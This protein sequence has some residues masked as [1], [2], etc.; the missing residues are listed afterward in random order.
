[1]IKQAHRK[2]RSEKEPYQTEWI[3]CWYFNY[4]YPPNYNWKSSDNPCHDSYYNS[5]RF[6]SR[7]IFAFQLGIIAKEGQD[8]KITFAVTNL[9]TT[10]P[11]QNTELRLF[12]YQN[13]H[14]QTLTTDNQGFASATFEKKPFFL[15]AQK[16]NQF[17]YPPS[18][19]G[20][21]LSTSTY[22]GGQVVN[23]RTER[24]YLWRTWCLASGDT[25]Y[26]NTIIEKGKNAGS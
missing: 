11:E 17:G 19:D 23:R 14:M 9:L 21:S 5:D 3:S 15:I 7:N 8:H 10:V 2:I 25:I 18:D 16:G 4:Y 13:R 24:I 6:V 12:N 26:L 22:V 20:S 1:M